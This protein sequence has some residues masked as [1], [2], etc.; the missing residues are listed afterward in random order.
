MSFG[1][2]NAPVFFMYL[3]NM[4]FMEE[5][6]IF[7]MVFIDDILIC[8]KTN[9]EQVEHL[10]IVLGRLRDHQLYAKFN[11][12]EFRL[13]EVAFLGHVLSENGVTVDPKKVQDVLK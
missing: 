5:L 3:M 9:E 7:V 4:V 8:S 10:C 2:I 12:C 1:L 6:G 11:K 13:R